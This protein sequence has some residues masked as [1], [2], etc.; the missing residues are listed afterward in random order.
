M[1]AADLLIRDRKGPGYLL[2]GITL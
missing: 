1:L 2:T